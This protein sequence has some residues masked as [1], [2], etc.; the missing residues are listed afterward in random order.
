MIIKYSV[1][2]YTDICRWWPPIPSGN[3]SCE[4]K[5]LCQILF[6]L[7]ALNIQYI[8][9]HLSLKHFLD[10]RC[11]TLLALSDTVE[12]G[13]SLRGKFADVA[14]GHH[15]NMC[16]NFRFISSILC[17]ILEIFTKWT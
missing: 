13:F 15:R 5:P 1:S 8:S 12:R 17:V 16:E 11:T 3:S 9:Y 10:V 6:V 4:L 7:F 14:S 2:L